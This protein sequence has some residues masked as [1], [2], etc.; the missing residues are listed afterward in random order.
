MTRTMEVAK[1]ECVK[2]EK[3]SEKQRKWLID[4]A[5]RMH[6]AIEDLAKYIRE[7]EGRNDFEFWGEV[8]ELM[9]KAESAILAHLTAKHKIAKTYYKKYYKK[10]YNETENYYKDLYALEY[11][12]AKRITMTVNNKKWAENVLCEWLNEERFEW[13][14]A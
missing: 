10:R 2:F 9:R 4:T 12:I 8:G 5:R 7:N 3:L 6:E 14:V 1:M 11:S 13:A